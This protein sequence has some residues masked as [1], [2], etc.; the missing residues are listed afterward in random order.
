MDKVWVGNIMTP[1]TRP[2]GKEFWFWFGVIGTI[3]TIV[4]G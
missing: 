1:V 3:L 4:N 2:R